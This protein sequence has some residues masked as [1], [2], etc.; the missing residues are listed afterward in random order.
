MMADAGKTSVNRSPRRTMDPAITLTA[1]GNQP[2]AIDRATG[3]LRGALLPVLVPLPALSPALR[4]SWLLPHDDIDLAVR[5]SAALDAGIERPAWTLIAHQTNPL[6]GR[7]EL[8][9][10]LWCA[11]ELARL[12]LPGHQ[13][14]WVLVIA[15]PVPAGLESDATLALT[16]VRDMLSSLNWPRWSGPL[17][18]VA[19]QPGA[20][21]PAPGREILIRPAMPM[22]RLRAPA[23][24]T[25]TA[26][27]LAARLS[28]VALELTGPPEQGWPAWL[29]V[30]LEEVA[31]AKVRGE[32]PSPLKMWALRQKAGT[33][34]LIALLTSATPDRELCEALCAPL[35][36]TKRRP[37][38]PNFLDLLRHG[39]DAPGALRLAYGLTIDQLVSER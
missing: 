28:T 38:L 34:A 32:G 30:G 29:Q 25:T 7:L 16:S 13:N 23:A 17:L 36:H 11:R 39:V 10:N 15:N 26:E 20:C 8:V 35:V 5:V 24:G 19:G 3:E 2:V 31:K 12:G 6:V 9:L 1:L 27:D 14:G 22:L 4:A 33:E 37:Q 18:L 21:D